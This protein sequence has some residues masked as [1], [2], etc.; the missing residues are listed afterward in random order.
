MRVYFPIKD[1]FIGMSLAWLYYKQ[2]IKQQNS[3]S[4]KNLS[5]ASSDSDVAA[6]NIM[7]ADRGSRMSRLRF[8][9]MLRGASLRKN[10]LKANNISGLSDN[11]E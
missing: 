7:L 8:N 11:E 2:G 1:F 6:L 4:D 10:T 9:S 3:Y 5:H